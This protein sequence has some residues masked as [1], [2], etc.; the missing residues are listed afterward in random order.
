MQN[1]SILFGTLFAISG[2]VAAQSRFQAVTHEQA[3]IRRLRQNVP[4]PGA[5]T[6]CLLW[7][8]CITTREKLPDDGVNSGIEMADIVGPGLGSC[9]ILRKVHNGR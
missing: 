9:A 8:R 7:G 6:R 5:S 1:S 2:F 4:A 3:V